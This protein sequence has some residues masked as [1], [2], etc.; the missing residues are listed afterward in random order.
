VIQHF[1]TKR[2]FSVYILHLYYTADIM[3]CKHVKND[4]TTLKLQWLML[5]S[6]TIHI[7]CSSTIESTIGTDKMVIIA[8]QS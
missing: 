7:Q 1:D 8:N 6:M 2:S 4:E 3:A 5:E